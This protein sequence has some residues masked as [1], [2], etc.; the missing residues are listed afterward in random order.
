MAE[1]VR[2]W[3]EMIIFN[4]GLQMSGE[5]R[6]WMLFVDGENLTIQ[7]ERFA[8]KSGITLVE[9]ANYL[10]E[11][12]VWLPG[13]APTN[14]FNGLRS[15]LHPYGMR[16][17][18]YTSMKADD[19]RIDAATERLWE[20]GFTPQVFKKIRKEDKAKG[21]DIALTKDMLIHAS[22]NHYE[23]ACLLAGDGDYVPLVEEVKRFGKIVVCIFFGGNG[24]SPTL[25]IACDEFLDVGPPFIESWK[26]V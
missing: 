19:S 8:A 2:V 1:A 16:A 17:Y 4:Q 9:G 7:A 18:Y 26:Q 3:R 13:R 6:T 25:K 20:L 15:Y 5:R 23:V 12:F 24:L 22:Q 21:V 14:S 10:K 11:T